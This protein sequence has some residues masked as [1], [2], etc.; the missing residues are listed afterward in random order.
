MRA[1]SPSHGRDAAA[2]LNDIVKDEDF[3]LS[4]K[5]VT[6]EKLPNVGAFDDDDRQTAET[7]F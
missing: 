2:G 1:T 5:N 4:D 6:S 3:E 7:V